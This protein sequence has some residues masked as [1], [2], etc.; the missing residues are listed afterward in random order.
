M[1]GQ[2]G[3]VLS[4]QSHVVHGHVGNKSATFPMQLLGLDVD[5]VRELKAKPSQARPRLRATAVLACLSTQ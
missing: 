4:I 3:R 1:A 5:P 2:Q